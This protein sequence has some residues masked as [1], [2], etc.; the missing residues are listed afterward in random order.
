[1]FSI[2]SAVF[3]YGT[4]SKQFEFELCHFLLHKWVFL[5][6]ES[7]QLILQHLQL[8]NI[9][10][11]LMQNCLKTFFYVAMLPLVADAPSNVCADLNPHNDHLT[12]TCLKEKGSK[13]KKTSMNVV[14]IN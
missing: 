5:Y 9:C 2:R 3:R 8:E 4:P 11:D 6:A 14:V 10:L 1:M 7:F 13:R 12:K